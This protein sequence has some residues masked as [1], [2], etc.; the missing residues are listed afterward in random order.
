[1][2]ALPHFALKVSM[3]LRRQDPPCI[4][5]YIVISSHYTQTAEF[6]FLLKL[7]VWSKDKTCCLP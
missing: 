5:T 2:L 4:L 7:K 3:P 1:M 6:G